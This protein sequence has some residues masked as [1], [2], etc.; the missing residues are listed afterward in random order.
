MLTITVNSMMGKQEI[1]HQQVMSY[2]IGGGNHDTNEKFQTLYW[3]A[4]SKY[5]KQE[6]DDRINC[7]TNGNDEHISELED[8]DDNREEE[9][10]D[11][12]EDID[13]GND[14][15]QNGY[16]KFCSWINNCNE[17]AV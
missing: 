5:V 11:S 8:T 16:P 6:I 4:F 3:G 14:R 1:S 7:L 13:E 17:S 2:L 9:D 15:Q 10:P 12:D